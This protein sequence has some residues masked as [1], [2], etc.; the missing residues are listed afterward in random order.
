[1]EIKWVF[2][3]KSNVCFMPGESAVEEVQT[4]ICASFIW[5]CQRCL[6]KEINFYFSLAFD[7]ANHNVRSHSLLSNHTT[8]W[9]KQQNNSMCFSI[10]PVCNGKEWLEDKNWLTLASEMFGSDGSVRQTD[11]KNCML[12]EALREFLQGDNI[13]RSFI[14][15]IRMKLLQSLTVTRKRWWR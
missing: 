2:V 9:W 15:E 14:W 11:R 12:Q 7:D 6:C 5:H 13:W 8:D 1:M 10:L 4:L 3:W